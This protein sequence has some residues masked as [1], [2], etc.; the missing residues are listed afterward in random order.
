M[1]FKE[2]RNKIYE[3]FVKSHLLQQ[4]QR[5]H[6]FKCVHMNA[7]IFVSI[8]YG[9]TPLCER[10]EPLENYLHTCALKFKA[11]RRF[12]ACNVCKLKPNSRLY[13]IYSRIFRCE[14]PNLNLIYDE[15]V[16]HN[17]CFNHNSHL[18]HWKTGL[19]PPEEILLRKLFYGH[20]NQFLVA[21]FGILLHTEKCKFFTA[22]RFFRDSI[23][24]N[25]NKWLFNCFL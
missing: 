24:I 4:L 21:R 18:I 17:N 16:L 3:D 10:V 11:T 12:L 5:I 8:T 9:K 20:K 13:I 2:S 7:R 1:K 14:Q 6:V 23:H 25:N 19:S 22:R 15:R